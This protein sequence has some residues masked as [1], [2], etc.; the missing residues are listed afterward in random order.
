MVDTY[1]AKVLIFV[2]SVTGAFVVAKILRLRVRP[3]V[4][5]VLLLNLLLHWAGR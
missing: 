2:T 3:V 4:G 5:V 1:W